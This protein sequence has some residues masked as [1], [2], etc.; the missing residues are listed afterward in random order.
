MMIGQQLVSRVGHVSR[1]Y[2]LSEKSVC[3]WADESLF[4]TFLST[5]QLGYRTTK[6]CEVGPGQCVFI[7]RR[8]GETKLDRGGLKVRCVGLAMIGFR[9][10]ERCC[11]MKGGQVRACGVRWRTSDG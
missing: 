9:N 10:V 4:S 7:L 2:S 8:D 1:E 6:H 11:D 5:V 3:G